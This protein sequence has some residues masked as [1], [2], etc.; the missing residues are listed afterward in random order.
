MVKSFT[1]LQEYLTFYGIDK[2]YVNRYYIE[3]LKKD[4]EETV[5][6]IFE[7]PVINNTV[8]LIHGYFDHTGGMKNIINEFLSIGW[9]VIS[10]DLYGHGLST[11]PRAE[12]ND[13]ENYVK[14]LQAVLNF[15]KNANYYPHTVIAHSTGAAICTHFLLQSK[16]KFE[17][18]IFL[19]PLVRPMEWSKIL[20]ASK[21][22]PRFTNKLKRKFKENSSDREY[23]AFV[24]NDPL[25]CHFIS[26]KWVLA[27]IK[28]NKKV[29]AFS[30]ST[31]DL[32]IIQGTIDETV[33]WKFN[34]PFLKKKF[35][36]IQVAIIEKASHQLMNEHLK[37]R[38][39]VI[40]LI[41]N[42][43]NKG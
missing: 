25:Q 1:K 26:I 19:A 30:A 39:I 27:L 11:G 7:P 2:T 4:E 29:E 6:H 15:C 31:Q 37:I 23:L 35:P 14:T 33:D 22:V 12:I 40:T 20:V 34:L 5:I 17:K 9:R 3:K 8:L 41:K 36:N 28:W 10:Y 16:C 24:K 32:Y 38:N 43:L 21:F 18:V 13:F 42:Q